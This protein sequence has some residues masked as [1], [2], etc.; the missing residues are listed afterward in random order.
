MTVQDVL[1]AAY[2][3]SRL[4]RE[5]VDADEATELR[6]LVG[7]VQGQVLAESWP[8]APDVLG[9]SASVAFAAGGWAHPSTS[10]GVW[11]IETALGVE[12]IQVPLDEKDA[13]RT[14]PAVYRIGNT[15]KVAGNANDPTSGSLTFYHVAQPATPAAVGTTLDTRIPDAFL[16]LLSLAVARYL[17]VKTN[18]NGVRSAEIEAL[19]AE[20]TAERARW[21]E[22]LRSQSIFRVSTRSL[23]GRKVAA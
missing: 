12:V 20:W 18:A 4:T 17:A 10:F 1:D 23:L 7:R 6:L 9:T 22:Y 5:G 16:D 15:F 3:H 8:L 13:D 2:G 11:R 14:R 21:L 19:E